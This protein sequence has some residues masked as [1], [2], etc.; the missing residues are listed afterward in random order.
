MPNR[1]ENINSDILLW[2]ISCGDQHAFA[3]FYEYYHQK[4]APYVFSILKDKEQT[5]DILQEVFSKLWLQRQHINHIENIDAY[6]STFAR[7]RCL[8]LLTSNIRKQALEASYMQQQVD[9]D[10]F[11]SSDK[12]T[13]KEYYEWLDKAIDTLPSQQ[14]KVYLLSRIDRKKYLDIA[15]ELE[16][17]KETVK[18]YLQ[19]ANQSIKTYLNKHKDSVISLLLFFIFY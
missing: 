2:K 14:R 18:K 10:T 13:E 16:I 17:S 3:Q 5:E 6:L 8:N 19:L 1:N 12:P 7:N 4:L 15:N 11:L 9:E